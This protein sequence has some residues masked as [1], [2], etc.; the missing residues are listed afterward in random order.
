MIYV[1]ERITNMRK[2]L[3]LLLL[4][5]FLL[6]VHQSAKSYD[7]EYQGLQYNILRGRI[8]EVSGMA[9]PDFNGKIVIPSKVINPYEE[10]ADSSQCIVE[11]IG[12]NAF[13]DCRGITSIELPSSVTGINSGAFTNCSS[14]TEINLNKTLLGIGDNAFEGCTSLS[15]IVIPSSIKSLSRKMFLNCSSLETIELPSNFYSIEES[16]LEGCT[17]LKSISMPNSIHFIHDGSFKNCVS[18]KDVTIPF[19]VTYIGKEVF[20][21]CENLNSVTLSNRITVIE[22]EAF[23][24]C[25]SLNQINLTDSISKIG[26]T[27]F[28]DCL[29]LRNINVSS[30]NKVL[31]SIDGVLCNKTG[32][33]LILFPPGRI[34]GIVN[35][36]NGVKTI[37]EGALN[38][39]RF[40]NIQIPESVDLIKKN[41]F[42]GCFDLKKVICLTL[43]PPV[44]EEEVFANE[45]FSTATL[46]IPS[47]SMNNYRNSSWGKFYNIKSLEDIDDSGIDILEISSNDTFSVY[48]L[49]GVSVFEN[50]NLE[51]L[52][53]LKKGIYLLKKGTTVKKI[54]L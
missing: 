5:L 8:V 14:L 43:D 12:I 54:L 34:N 51:R 26:L 19:Y 39:C 37:G 7:F 6:I 45:T 41:A 1:V 20:A 13:R 40:E 4:S 52:K 10:L 29:E 33:W 27:A 42:Q 28:K 15:K 18:L 38:H 36:P 53:T 3:P 24:G 30:K 32:D 22:N 17:S 23:A 44:L 16:A 2:N 47:D 49:D 46:F 50:C 48:S 25:V 9:N 31:A 21:G 35:I 11:A